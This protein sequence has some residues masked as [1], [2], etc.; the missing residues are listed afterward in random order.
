MLI[1]KYAAPPTRFNYFKKHLPNGVNRRSLISH[2]S[3][4]YIFLNGPLLTRFFIARRAELLFKHNRL[5]AYV[6]G[7]FQKSV[8]KKK[9]EINFSSWKLELWD[10]LV[11]LFLSTKV[12]LKSTFFTL[13]SYRRLPEM[14]FV[15]KTLIKN[16]LLVHISE[17]KF[18][19]WFTCSHRYSERF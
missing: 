13:N 15:S 4:P 7:N 5:F 2:L 8:K 17:T 3:L 9:S 1:R 18:F 10:F 16:V 12:S 19:F 14:D 11:M 6:G